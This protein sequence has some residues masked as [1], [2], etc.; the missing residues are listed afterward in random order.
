MKQQS[1]LRYLAFLGGQ[2]A[3]QR[4][5]YES[6]FFCLQPSVWHVKMDVVSN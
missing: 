3:Q 6:H 5:F 4:D 1:S 2:E